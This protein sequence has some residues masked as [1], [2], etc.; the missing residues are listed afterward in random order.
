MSNSYIVKDTKDTEK[1][2]SDYQL[3]TPEPQAT[4]NNF[5]SENRKK[6][7]NIE[8]PIYSKVTNK[9]A[10]WF[11]TLSEILDVIKTGVFTKYTPPLT[12][13]RD[14][15]TKIFKIREL[16]K[17]LEYNASLKSDI[18]KIKS[19]L[20]PFIL[21]RNS[22]KRDQYFT[23][24]E[25]TGLIQVDIDDE[26]NPST[27]EALKKDPYLLTV[28]KSPKGIGTKGIIYHNKGM[29]NHRIVFDNIS[30]YFY[31]NYNIQIDNKVKDINRFF[32][33]SFDDKIHINYDFI[34]FDKEYDLKKDYEYSILFNDDATPE[35]LEIFYKMIEN[36]NINSY[37][38]YFKI[39]CVAYNIFK[40]EY[41]DIKPVLLK[42][43]NSGYDEKNNISMYEGLKKNNENREN[44]YNLFTIKKLLELDNENY[45]K[46]HIKVYFDKLRKKSKI[47]T[48]DFKKIKS[49]ISNET[50]K[51]IID[52]LRSKDQ[53]LFIKASTG[54]GKTHSM[55]LYFLECIKEGKTPIYVCPTKINQ[56]TFKKTLK[57]I[58]KD[59]GVKRLFDVGIRTLNKN[60]TDSFY[61]NDFKGAIVLNIY[62]DRQGE[63]TTL[64]KLLNIIKDVKN[65]VILVDEADKLIQDFNK[66]IYLTSRYKLRE[67]RLSN[68]NFFYKCPK[69]PVFGKFGNCLNCEK[70][71]NNSY[72]NH[73]FNTFNYRTSKEIKDANRYNTDIVDIKIN[74]LLDVFLIDDSNKKDLSDIN[75]ILYPQDKNRYKDINEDYFN[76][77]VKPDLINVLKH[78]LKHSI[79]PV[80]IKYIPTLEN[81]E[82][83]IDKIK[84]L[85]N[86]AKDKSNNNNL[87]NELLCKIKYPSLPC[88]CEIF[89]YFDA[90]SLSYLRDL[91]IE[92]KM[93][94]GTLSTS[95]QN[96]LN[97]VFNDMKVIEC[98]N[99]N[100]DIKINNILVVG[101]NKDIDLHKNN[102]LKFNLRS[103]NSNMVK[104]TDTKA[105]AIKL[106][107]ELST[108][109][110][111]NVWLFQ[112]GDYYNTET[113][114][115]K[116]RNELLVTYSYSSLSRGANLKEY[117]IIV[118]DSSFKP[119]LC[120]IKEYDDKD[121]IIEA[122]YTDAIEIAI[123]NA[124]RIL[125]KNKKSEH[126]NKIIIF[127]NI[128]DIEHLNKLIS[129]SKWKDI[130]I[131]DLI[132]DYL[133]LDDYDNINK[134]INE[135]SKEFLNNNKYL[136]PL[137]NKEYK[138]A[139]K[140]TKKDKKLTRK[141][142]KYKSSGYT[143]KQIKDK[144]N[145]YKGNKENKEK[146]NII[147]SV[148]I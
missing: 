108:C 123:Q 8:I 16:N 144:L 136:Q 109:N 127:E 50:D 27:L 75:M 86:N 63:N 134:T 47:K 114:N 91:N 98:K 106:Y 56:E 135:I 94:S 12:T 13:T 128:V 66:I 146:I 61:N 42:I 119:K 111:A 59:T 110:N 32:Y 6:I 101:L 33:M 137:K 62:L 148:N 83:S 145:Y 129:M 85:L 113:N 38:K 18:D 31:N 74:D 88:N 73:L 19:D 17:A 67:V 139:E 79:N 55:A 82:I 89:S 141:I 121:D 78:I 60:S 45:Y 64:Y 118:V 124:G 133:Y 70:I 21:S 28:F 57:K 4:F 126:N 81:N 105:N 147:L 138:V 96:Y 51:N 143:D 95:N 5:T 53:H 115:K 71:I 30:C 69:C 48:I 40:L 23:E 10:N 132:H 125:R 112:D 122:I 1:N 87:I 44:Y 52:L 14:I 84:E 140:N 2:Q 22:N 117:D 20:L 46:E 116:I 92:I 41:D 93:L 54:S 77:D 104:F 49:T 58:L 26:I 39:I 36:I 99:A 102:K 90:F 24:L 29:A 7:F 11:M 131:N 100:D 72:N 107:N 35:G 97:D 130:V 15:K 65:P 3:L 142:K 34:P 68:N 76:Y 120:Y 37:D 103:I 43:N 80:I 25:Y 9:N